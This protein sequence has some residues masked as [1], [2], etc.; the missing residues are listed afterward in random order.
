MTSNELTE[1]VIRAAIDVHRQ[2]GPG[3][4]ESVY[5]TCLAIEMRREHL[6]VRTEVPIPITYR[7]QPVAEEGFRIDLLVEDALVVELKSVEYLRPVHA[8]QVLT[9]LRLGG[10]HIGLLMN[11]HETQLIRGVRRIVDGLQG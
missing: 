5:E 4:L 6:R 8:K 10:F 1:R 9:Y 11:F 7:G 3:L 2:L